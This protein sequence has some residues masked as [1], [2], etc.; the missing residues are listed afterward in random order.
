MSNIESENNKLGGNMNESEIRQAAQMYALVAEMEAAKATIEG[1]K[2]ENEH[3][4]SQ[5][6]PPEFSSDY[7]F[8][9]DA[10]LVRIAIRLRN[11]I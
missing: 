6:L 5:G 1:M 10:E 3:R 4:T 7:F 2:V 9:A 11:E 8:K